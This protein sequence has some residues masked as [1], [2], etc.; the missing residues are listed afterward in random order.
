VIGSVLGGMIGNRLGQYVG[1]HTGNMVFA[2]GAVVTNPA[3]VNAANAVANHM[4]SPAEA[5]SAAATG[6]SMGECPQ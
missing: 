3:A 2:A 4:G 1:H 6:Q 5:A